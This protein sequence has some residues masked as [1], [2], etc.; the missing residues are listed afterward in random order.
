MATY[1]AKGW[2]AKF[3]I[4]GCILMAA[5]VMWAFYNSI[6]TWDQLLTNKDKFLLNWKPV[7]VLLS[8]VAI[9]SASLKRIK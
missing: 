2:A 4:L 5:G 6:Y 9:M 3:F 7:L 8:G 1:K